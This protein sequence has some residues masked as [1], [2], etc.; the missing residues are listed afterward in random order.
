F[1]LRRERRVQASEWIL[2]PRES[3]RARPTSPARRHRAQRGRAVVDIPRPEV[4]LG[5]GRLPVVG[6]RTVSQ[7]W[8]A[9]NA[10]KPFVFHCLPCATGIAS[11]TVLWVLWV[12]PKRA[13]PTSPMEH[14]LGRVTADLTG[15]DPQTHRTHRPHFTPDHAP[16][17]M[18]EAVAGCS[19]LP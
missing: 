5:V 16:P 8:G 12:F 19:R 18:A 2:R 3:V 4:Q 13:W 7:I 14:C 11:R 17:P 1:L 9:G 15:N 6:S 10:E